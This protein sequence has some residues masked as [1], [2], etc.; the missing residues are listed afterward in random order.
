MLKAAVDGCYCVVRL[1]TKFLG[2]FGQMPRRKSK[3]I[4]KHQTKET[5]PGEIGF[6]VEI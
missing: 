4:Q 1:H 2:K 6:L 3:K 5:S